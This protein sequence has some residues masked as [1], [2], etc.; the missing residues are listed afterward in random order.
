M[1]WKIIYDFVYV[2]HRNINHRIHRFWDISPNIKK[3]HIDLSDLE[4]DL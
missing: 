4:C 3:V 1:N 2:F